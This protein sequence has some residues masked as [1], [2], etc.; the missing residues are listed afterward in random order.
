MIKNSYLSA[1]ESEIRNSI[2]ILSP[3]DKKLS[4]SEHG[5]GKRVPLANIKWS[6]VLGMCSLQ[7]LA[8]SVTFL[9]VPIDFEMLVR[10]I[11]F[12]LSR[13]ELLKQ[14][15]LKMCVRNIQD[16]LYQNKSLQFVPV[17]NCPSQTFK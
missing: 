10:G 7:Y 2:V 14:D 6:Q 15:K 11:F 3:V 16:C 5:L 12:D 9:D 1:V 4:A 13:V 17:H 8:K